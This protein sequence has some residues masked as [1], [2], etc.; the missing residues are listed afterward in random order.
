VSWEVVRGGVSWMCDCG[1]GALGWSW[2]FRA[3]GV[4]SSEGCSWDGL[5]DDGREDY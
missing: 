2:V 4:D 1:V 5:S 3:V